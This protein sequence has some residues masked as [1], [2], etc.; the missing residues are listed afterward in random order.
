MNIEQT[1]KNF[2]HAIELTKEGNQLI[3]EQYDLVME[4]KE[5]LAQPGIHSQ[6]RKTA[7]AIMKRANESTQAVETQE[8]FISLTKNAILNLK[9]IKNVLETERHL[10]H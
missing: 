10:A 3:D 2:K 8:E 7:E 6:I 1:M 9:T 4:I 5:L